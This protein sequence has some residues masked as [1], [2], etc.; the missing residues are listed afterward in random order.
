MCVY[1][2]H[3]A[4]TPVLPEVMEGMRPYF[5]EQFGNASS[6]HSPGLA[7][8]EALKKVREQFAVFVNAA[9]PEEIIFTSNGTEAVNLAIKGAALANEK[10]G[11]HIVLSAIEHPA[12]NGSVAWL[13]SLG[14]C[15]TKVQVDRTGFV[16]P[17]AI[18]E[19]LRPDTIMVCIHHANHDL[20][21]IQ[22]AQKIGELCAERGLLFFVD[23]VASAGWAEVNVQSCQASLVSISPHRFYGPKGVG[24]LYRNRRTRLQSLI[25]G[26]MQEDGRRAG[27]ENIPA[28]VGAGIAAELARSRLNETQ[29]RTAHLQKLLWERLSKSIPE[30]KL[31]GPELGPTRLSTNLNLSFLRLEGEG[32]ALA[33]DMKGIA[34]AAG[35]ACVTKEMRIP[36]TLQAIGLSEH[37]AKGT[38]IVSLGR[39]NEVE[40]IEYVIDTLPKVVARLREMSP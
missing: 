2:D 19:A 37:W 26:G 31:N 7:A 5:A 12:V 18:H 40:E 11:K 34:V 23:A 39:E 32:L 15:A 3:Q 21:T 17:A 16:D 6:L 38:I 25:H 29:G 28:I 1:L 30:I 10:R 13:E 24:V 20:G 4:A 22:R 14:F 27:T 35:A 9:F 33:L 8:R 36:P